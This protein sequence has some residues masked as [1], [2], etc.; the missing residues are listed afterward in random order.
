MKFLR[1]PQ[2]GVPLKTKNMIFSS[3]SL[4]LQATW[5]VKSTFFKLLPVIT[6]KGIS[7]L[8][9]SQLTKKLNALLYPKNHF[10]DSSKQSFFCPIPVTSW[11]CA[12]L[13]SLSSTFPPQ[14]FPLL[15]SWPP[16]ALC[17][18]GSRLQSWA[19]TALL[20]LALMQVDSRVAYTVT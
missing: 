8:L 15:L 4:R 7:S 18:V 19:L 14:G 12:S 11:V 13:P 10:A 20:F 17:G 16:A 9:L 3:P 6:S 5:Q 2:Y 1:G